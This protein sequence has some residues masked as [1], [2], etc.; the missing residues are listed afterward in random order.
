VFIFRKK[1]QEPGKHFQ[2]DLFSPNDGIY[3]YSALVT[4]TQR[5]EAKELL[6]FISGRSGQENS[7]SE[8]KDDFAFG[9][10]SNQH[11]PGQF[12]LLSGQP[13]GL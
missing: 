4:D 5:W 3:E 8:L 2:F 6:L 9:L 12:C 13:N 11:L 1:A 10:C 7:L